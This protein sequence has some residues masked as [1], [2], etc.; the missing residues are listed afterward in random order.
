MFIYALTCDP[1]RWL[2]QN[3][4]WPSGI[5]V[6]PL[7]AVNEC[8]AGMQWHFYS[9]GERKIAGNDASVT[10]IL[11]RVCYIKILTWKLQYVL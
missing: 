1:E 8:K 5:I 11:Q 2:Y 4:L 7:K 6:I 3:P 9:A 10:Q